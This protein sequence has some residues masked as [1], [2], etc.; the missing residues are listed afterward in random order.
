MRPKRLHTPPTDDD[1]KELYQ[2]SAT[3]AGTIT[4][5][6][7]KSYSSFS[8][9]S[10]IRTFSTSECPDTSTSSA[11]FICLISD[12]FTLVFNSSFTES[13][14]KGE[15]NITRPLTVIGDFDVDVH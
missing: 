4:E 11:C 1:Y 7:T 5:S 2:A 3:Y 13:S 6:T 9:R 10:W 15:R 14:C 8:S 12:R